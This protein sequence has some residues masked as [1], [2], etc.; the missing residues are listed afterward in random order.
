MA[1]K[2]RMQPRKFI[3]RLGAEKVVAGTEDVEEALSDVVDAEL[4]N[5]GRQQVKREL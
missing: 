1:T 3:M 2:S 5:D 4:K